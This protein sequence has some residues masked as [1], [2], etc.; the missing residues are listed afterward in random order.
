MGFQRPDF[1]IRML[2]NFF[3]GNTMLQLEI[4]YIL[5]ENVEAYSMALSLALSHVDGCKRSRV[6]DICHSL[7]Q[8]RPS[9]TCS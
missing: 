9:R 1:V 5:K 3:L 6:R 4:L 8:S 7:P 2:D